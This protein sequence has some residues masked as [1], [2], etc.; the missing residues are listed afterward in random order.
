MQEISR[1]W[2]NI[3]ICKRK[4]NHYLGMMA[5][6]EN[7]RFSAARGIGSAKLN[8]QGRYYAQ[9]S[10]AVNEEKKA[11]MEIDRELHRMVLEIHVELREV[12][13]IAA[14]L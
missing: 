12:R 9:L 14:N 5:S 3:V 7:K 10:Q 2:R 6:E 1:G 11:L 8:E 13:D 4:I